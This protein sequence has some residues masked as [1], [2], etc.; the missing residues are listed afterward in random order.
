VKRKIVSL[1]AASLLVAPFLFPS[2]TF[3]ASRI[4]SHPGDDGDG[5]VNVL[6]IMPVTVCTDSIT[7]GL[8]GSLFNNTCG[9]E[10]EA[11]TGHR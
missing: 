4:A 8:L 9:N 3:A 5:D 7:G 11:S 1:V 2:T 10:A 6:Q